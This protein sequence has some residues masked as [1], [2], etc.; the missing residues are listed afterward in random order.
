M[1]CSCNR[2]KVKIEKPSVNKTKRYYWVELIQS[3]EFIEETSQLELEVTNGWFQWTQRL[4]RLVPSTTIHH[5]IGGWFQPQ[6]FT[7]N[8]E[9][10]RMS[11]LTR[12]VLA[13]TRVLAAIFHAGAGY[14]QITDDFPATGDHLVLR[15]P[16]DH[17]NPSTC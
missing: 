8:V 12:F 5:P 17:S 15:N 13:E 6:W 3:S 14:I 7:V 2:W 1:L 16:E 9:A 4:L 10:W 11:C